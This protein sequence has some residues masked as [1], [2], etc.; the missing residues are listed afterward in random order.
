MT[1]TRLHPKAHRAVGRW[2]MIDAASPLK[3]KEEAARLK[4]DLLSRLYASP[5]KF[6]SCLSEGLPGNHRRK[7]KFIVKKS[8]LFFVAAILFI[9]AIANGAGAGGFAQS[10]KQG[11]NS[12]DLAAPPKPYK[13]WEVETQLPGV[14]LLE[15][16]KGYMVPAQLFVPPGNK[17]I[18]GSEF[19]DTL[20]GRDVYN[21][22]LMDYLLIHQ[23]EI[24]QAWRDRT[25]GL[26]LDGIFFPGTIYVKNG[27]QLVPGMYKPTTGTRWLNTFKLVDSPWGTASPVAIH[28]RI[29]ATDPN[30]APPK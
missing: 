14:G 23:E 27:K 22:N 15:W 12:V 1:G 25:E 6:L 16:P 8:C 19:L 5:S 11:M 28:L 3:G 30:S 20:K 21:R 2:D 24:P 4:L 10:S 7:R 18:H 17:L 9:G 29:P 13:G 26:P